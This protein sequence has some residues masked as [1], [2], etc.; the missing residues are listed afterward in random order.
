MNT[1]SYIFVAALLAHLG[2][3]LWLDRRHLRHVRANRA[4]VPAAFAGQIPLA[5]HQKAADYTMARL[6]FGAIDT[7]IGALVLLGWT[8][9]GGFNALDQWL[10]GLGMTPLASGVA[11]I[12]VAFMLMALIDL[13]SQIYRTFVIEHRFG[14]NRTDRRTFVTDLVK[15]AGLMLVLGIPL[16]ALVLWLM[17]NS[18]EYWWLY[19]WVTW[20][21]F[22]LLMLWAFPVLI[23]PLFNK[24]EPL[25]DT[26]LVSRIDGLLARTGFRSNG[27]FVMDGS[28]RSAH[29]NAY[30]TGF[31]AN[32]RIVFFDTLLKE[33]NG[34]EIEAVLAHELG[35][36]KRR[37][38]IKRV[39][40]MALSSL[41]GLAVLGWLIRQ[42][43]FYNGLGVSTPSVHMAL[44]LFLT[45][46][47]LFTF[48]LQP[49]MSG[50]SRA[51]E[52]EADAY[53]V[54]QADG[55][56]LI[57]ALVKLYKENANTL[58]P[59]PIYSAYH[60]SHPPAPIRIAHVQALMA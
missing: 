3:Q 45:V 59:D 13:P 4:A 12:I 10:R 6:R 60:D 41:I 42:P 43:W 32:K 56:S 16:S 53:A 37:H 15:S 20:T 2:V 26:A 38:V 5:A 14:F 29:G 11:F 33:L 28:R 7:I 49:L 57:R 34:E 46:A 50:W 58:T 48:L 55:N 19:V 36:F 9:G 47:P 31:G 44:V 8:L 18:G 17:Q 39:V 54:E 24:F 22:S 40:V 1:F 30:F 23:A 21:A 27:I 35:H 25:A 51:H 52:F